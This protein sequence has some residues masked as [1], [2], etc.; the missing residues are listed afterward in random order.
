ME[1]ETRKK[2]REYTKELNEALTKTANEI[3][4]KYKCDAKVVS[5][6][7]A[8]FVS[9]YLKYIAQHAPTPTHAYEY[10]WDAKGVLEDKL[11]DSEDELAGD[12]PDE[13]FQKD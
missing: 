6:A 13:Y 1:N 3:L 4:E 8:R 9:E 7:I 10:F 11:Q 5:K 2:N 12:V